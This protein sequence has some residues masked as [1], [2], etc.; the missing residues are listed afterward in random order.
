MK[1]KTFLGIGLVTLLAGSL[2]LLSLSATFATQPT[3]EPPRNQKITVEVFAP[4]P[5]DI[6]GISNRAFLVDLAADFKGYDLAATGFTTPELTGP[7]A[8]NN[9]PPFPAP[10]AAGNNTK[11]PGLIV[12]LSTTTLGAGQG[13]NLA[14]L[15]NIVTVTD[16]STIGVVPA[17]EL[18][19]TWIVGAAS[20]GTGD[21]HLIIAISADKN[22]NGIFDDAPNVVP[23]ANGDGNIDA[24]D[25][26]AFGVASNVVEVDFVINANP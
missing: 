8:H 14:G 10:F 7:G 25:L 21:S 3:S 1:K 4:G 18:W 17:T 22:G 12:L 16:R 19:A 5:G 26:V 2:A 9:V 23:D 20:F 15:F 24:K 6:A 13:Q 11:F